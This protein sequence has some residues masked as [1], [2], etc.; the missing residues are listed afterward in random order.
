MSVSAVGSWF[1]LV[2]EKCVAALCWLGQARASSGLAGGCL[3]DG[4]C[5]SWGA[6]V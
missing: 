1:L 6:S 2:P 5:V 4:Q 3:W